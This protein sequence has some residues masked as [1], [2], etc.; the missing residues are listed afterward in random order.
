MNAD[1]IFMGCRAYTLDAANTRAEAIAVRDGRIAGIGTP[2]ELEHLRGPETRVIDLGGRTV[3][4]GLI[5]SH[6]H[7]VHYGVSATRSVDL[8]GCASI[9]EVLVR[10]RRFRSANLDAPWLLGQRFDQGLFSEGRWITRAD[11]DRVSSEVPIMVTRLCLHALVANS[12]AIAPIRG[13]ITRQQAE[14]GLFTEDATELIWAQVPTPTPSERRK[15]ARWALGEARRV[16]LAGVHCIVH[17]QEDFDAMKSL[18]AD[19]DLPVRVRLMVSPNL[20]DGL[21]FGAGDDSFRIGAVKLFVDGSMG[22]R[23]AAMKEPFTDDPGNRGELFCDERELP[24]T[25]VEVQRKGFQA[26][27]HAIGDLA[28]ECALRAIE[29]AMPMGNTGNTLRHR[30]EHAS[31][32]SGSLVKTMA[33]LRVPASVQPQFVT[34]DFWTRDCVGAERYAWS[35]PFRT[36][37]QAGIMLGM[38]SD[39]PVER[40]NPIDLIDRAVNREQYSAQERLSVEETLRAYAYGSAFLGFDE[41][42]RGSIEVGKLAD[43]TV[44][45]DDVFEVSTSQ[46]AD[47]KVENV[48]LEGVMQ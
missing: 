7:L 22:A 38:G 23:T 3:I 15:A 40:L 31:Q 35:Y 46:I 41:K 44:L 1:T 32:M 14:T 11:L 9:E 6:A 25:L 18:H 20:A 12:A 5:D 24:R 27:I 36:M 34:T 4:P 2:E 39:C 42:S 16:G 13:G 8:T 21:G 29:I 30:I 26:A 28:V 43:L 10:L 33:R 17:S 47:I 48:V 45:S 37:L 19:S